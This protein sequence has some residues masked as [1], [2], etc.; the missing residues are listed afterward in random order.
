MVRYKTQWGS[1]RLSPPLPHPI[2]ATM[3]TTFFTTIVLL[4][5]LA[6]ASPVLPNR[7]YR[8]H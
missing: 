1:S 2:A 4:V 3:K 7:E 5:G 8:E 6:A